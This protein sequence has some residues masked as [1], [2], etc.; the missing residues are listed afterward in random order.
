M[1]A[2]AV[3]SAV[4]KRAA[5]AAPSV[6]RDLAGVAGLGFVAYGAHE[7]FHPIGW[8]VLGLELVAG[9]ALVTAA[10][11]RAAARAAEASQA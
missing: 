11:A 7:V 10:K 8:I 4:G 3:L 2:R 1:Q 9:V 5:A 6:V